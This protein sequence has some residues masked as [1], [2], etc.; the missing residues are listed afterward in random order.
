MLISYGLLYIKHNNIA[1]DMTATSCLM[2][3]TKSDVSISVIKTVAIDCHPAL[4][5]KYSHHF[6]QL[7]IRI[8]HAGLD[9]I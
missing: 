6:S 3:F 1:C 5:V 7:T 8:E 9:S 4:G 2:I